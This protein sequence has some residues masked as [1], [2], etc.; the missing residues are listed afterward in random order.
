MT[1]SSPM[2][3]SQVT[4]HMTEYKKFGEAMRPAKTII[5]APGAEM[6]QLVARIA[7]SGAKPLNYNH[8]K[9]PLMQNLAKRAVRSLG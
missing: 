9:I 4:M 5:E 8:F 6:E 7:A 3:E 2:G 1:Q